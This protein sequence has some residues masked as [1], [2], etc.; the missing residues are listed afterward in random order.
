MDAVIDNFDRCSNTFIN[1][2]KREADRLAD[3]ME[4]YARTNARWQDRTGDARAG[5]KAIVVDATNGSG[6][7]IAFG[8]SVYYGYFLENHFGG[9]YAIIYETMNW[10]QEQLNGRM[11]TDVWAMD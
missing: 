3:R 10:A 1:R 6:F 7:T 4:N 11:A 8:H 2:T 5:L 9:Q